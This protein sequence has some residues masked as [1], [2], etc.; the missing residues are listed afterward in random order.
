MSQRVKTMKV[1]IIGSNEY[2]QHNPRG[3]DPE[4]IYSKD[5]KEITEK[6]TNKTNSDIERLYYLE[7]LS[8]SYIDE[9][10]NTPY[11]PPT[12][13]KGALYAAAKVRK[14]GVKLKNGILI[15]DDCNVPQFKFA[16]PTDVYERYKKGYYHRSIEKVGQAKVVRT[17]PKFSEWIAIFDIIYFEN[18][19]SKTDLEVIL[20]DAG[21]FGIGDSRPIFGRFSHK[22][23]K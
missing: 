19:I 13:L 18:V 21:M 7:Y 5:I 16:G 9:E 11:M 20:S 22:F 8:S 12:H 15:D 2:L 23:I 3:V 17:R 10:K 6:K 4:C 14:F 1:K